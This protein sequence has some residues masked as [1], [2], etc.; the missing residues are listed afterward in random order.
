MGIS[1]ELL[2]TIQEG[3]IS[4][5][6]SY[7]VLDVPI[8]RVQAIEM[9]GANLQAEVVRRLEAEPGIA[10]VVLATVE[11]DRSWCHTVGYVSPMVAKGDVAGSR[12]CAG[13]FG[14]SRGTALDFGTRPRCFSANASAS[15]V[16]KSPTRTRHALFGT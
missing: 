11:M 2:Q 6:A 12:V 3:K 9:A 1:Q 5:K 10:D 16:S 15:A 7:A 8:E 14:M 13:S 4:F